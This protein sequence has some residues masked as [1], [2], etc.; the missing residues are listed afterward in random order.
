LLKQAANTPAGISKK[1]KLKLK[2]K[3]K[4]EALKQ[5]KAAG[6]NGSQVS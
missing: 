4:K 5:Q 6:K 1:E 2:K 3:A